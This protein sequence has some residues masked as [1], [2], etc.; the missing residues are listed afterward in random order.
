MK[1]EIL[2]IVT[3]SIAATKSLEIVKLLTKNYYTVPTVLTNGAKEFVT[4]LSFISFSNQ[5]CHDEMFSPDEELKMSHISLAR[6]PN[7]ILVAPATAD[8]IAKMAH[9]FADDLASTLILAT[10]KPV[11]VAPAMNH[12]MWENKITQRNVQIL[13]DIGMTILEP[14]LGE[15]ACGEFGKGRMVEPQ[16]IYNYVTQNF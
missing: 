12:L 14:T 8:F 2:L 1:K 10:N 7:A 16:D 6:S 15:L 11:I 3:G 9:G 4:K 13:R 5:P